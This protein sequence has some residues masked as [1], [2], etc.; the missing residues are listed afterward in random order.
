MTELQSFIV[1]LV[2]VVVAERLSRWLTDDYSPITRTE[3]FV[4]CLFYA[5]WF[6][7]G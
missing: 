6:F 1:A 5:G 3:A 4:M 2:M 7:H